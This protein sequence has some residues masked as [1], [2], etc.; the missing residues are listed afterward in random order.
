MQLLPGRVARVTFD[1]GGE[2]AK[3]AKAR[4]AWLC[5]SKRGGVR[6]YFPPSPYINVVVYYFP[7]EGENEDI[8]SEMKKFGKVNTWRGMPDVFSGSRVVVR[9]KE[10]PHAR[11]KSPASFP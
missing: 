5:H 6:G 2:A 9:E 4:G 1:K 7:F 11:R 3:A 10:I 8:V